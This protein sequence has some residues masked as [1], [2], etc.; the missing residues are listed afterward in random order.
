MKKIIWQSG[1]ARYY[2][3]SDVK[4]VKLYIHTPNPAQILEIYLHKIPYPHSPIPADKLVSYL[5]FKMK[6]MLNPKFHATVQEVWESNRS[7]LRRKF[8]NLELATYCLQK[9]H[10]PKK[11]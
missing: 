11:Q 1:S 5:P 2:Q 3:L 6:S 9:V 10:R 7:G 4:Y 8:T